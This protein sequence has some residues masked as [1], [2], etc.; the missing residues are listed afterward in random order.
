[1]LYWEEHIIRTLMLIFHHN[2]CA[3]AVWTA[4]KAV[5]GDHIRVQGC[6]FPP[7][8]QYLAESADS[9]IDNVLQRRR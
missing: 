1:M 3:Q 4:A 6:F 2:L 5:F 9:G 8:P 7:H